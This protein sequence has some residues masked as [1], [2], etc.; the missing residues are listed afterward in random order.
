MLNRKRLTEAVLRAQVLDEV[1]LLP[2]EL[3]DNV[4]LKCPLDFLV[5]QVH[6]VG[7]ML[8]FVQVPALSL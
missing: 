5:E 1:D 4:N 7:L 8:A 3:A 6:T 2:L